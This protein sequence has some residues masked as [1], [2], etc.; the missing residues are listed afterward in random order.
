MS[1]VQEKVS[2]GKKGRPRIIRPLGNLECYES[3]MILLGFYANTI[4]NCR[5][6]I[7]TSLA[8]P[9]LHDQLI[10]QL[11][12]AIGRVV[13]EHPA[14]RV[15]IVEEDSKRPAWV[16]VDLIDLTHHV[17]WQIVDAATDY[18][19]LFRE[20]IQKRL[21]EPYS[22]IPMR[23]RWRVLLLLKQGATPFV[24]VVFDYSHGFADGTSGKIFHETLLRILNT[25]TPTPSETEPV[26]TNRVLRIPPTVRK[27]PP[28]LEKLCKFQLSPKYTL[29]IAWKELKPRGFISKSASRADWAPIRA[30]PFKT[31]SRA[32]DVE[33][34]VLQ[35]VLAACRT[36]ETTLTGL[37]HAV[38][39]ASLAS[40]LHPRDAAAFAGSTALDMRRH[41]QPQPAAHPGLEPKR[42]MADFVSAMTHDFDA[43]LVRKIREAAAASAFPASSSLRERDGDDD[44]PFPPALVDLVWQCAAQV[45]AEIQKRLDLGLKNDIVG[46]MKLVPD[47]RAQFRDQAR[48]PRACSVVVTNLGALDGAA[49]PANDEHISPGNR[50][51]IE[52]ALFG[53]SS[54]V[55]G[56]AFAIS[57]ISVKGKTLCVSCSWQDC[58]LDV[59]LAETIV[60]DLERWLRFLGKL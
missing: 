41:M 42:T 5:Y 38:A 29:S 36:H 50:W 22:K 26:L 23:P 39:L 48:K 8:A 9:H 33:P 44:T 34:E 6:T 4:V 54:E 30:S 25:S 47:W 28:P 55:C 20:R 46:V 31:Q 17:E 35:K 19:T 13:I 3:H 14:L 57:P 24:D 37:L 43:E 40:R 15:G 60:A 1:V 11:E 32:F 56:A 2:S 16:E 52:R 12:D 45:R 53:I 58:V 18:D 27:L 7:P 51:E 59:K 10:A 49:A 21:D